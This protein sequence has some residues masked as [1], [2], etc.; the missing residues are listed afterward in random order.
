MDERVKRLAGTLTVDSKPGQGAT[1][2]AELPFP[3]VEGV[4][5]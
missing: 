1:L 2:T 5:S 3:P 4:I